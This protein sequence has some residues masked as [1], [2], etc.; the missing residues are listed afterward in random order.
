MAF[1]AVI[2][3]PALFVFLSSATS[4]IAA[5]AIAAH[6]DPILFVRFLFV[7]AAFAV[8]ARKVEWPKGWQFV[9]RVV[10]QY[11]SDELGQNLTVVVDGIDGRTHHIA[12][13]DPVRAEGAFRA[14]ITWACRCPYPQAGGAAPRRHR[15]ADRP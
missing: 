1:A 3:A 13:V 9:G 8:L 10:D 4:F 14:A 2:A 7:I 15:Q 5:R 6:A 12:G 11:L